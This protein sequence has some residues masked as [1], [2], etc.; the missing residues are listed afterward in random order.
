MRFWSDEWPEKDRF[1]VWR[2]LV[3]T[4]LLRSDVQQ[5]TGDPFQALVYMRAL[6][7]LRFGW[8]AVGASQYERTKQIVAEDNNDFVLLM[9]LEGAFSVAQQG[10]SVKL[11]PGDAYLMSC[12]EVGA[13]HRPTNGKLLCVRLQHDAIAPAVRNV[14]EAV[15]RLIPRNTEGLRLLAGY[16]RLLDENDPLTSAKAQSLVTNHVRD[17]LALTLGA[18]SERE[19]EARPDS[20]LRASRLAAVK[21]YLDK[22]AHR[23][24]LTAETVAAHFKMSERSLQRLFQGEGT[25]FSALLLAKRLARAYEALGSGRSEGRAIAAIALDA[26]FGDVSYFNRSFKRRYGSSPAE[27]RQSPVLRQH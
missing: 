1:P 20:G 11:A 24:D 6:P 16:L 26:G 23:P 12:A 4:R 8:G 25:T 21:A 3:S 18:L 27:V 15:G 9:N 19:A 5:L 17:L 13:Y 10:N 2:E 14:Y 7:A 22:H